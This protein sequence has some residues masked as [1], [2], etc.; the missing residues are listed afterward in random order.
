MDHNYLI[1]KGNKLPWKIPAEMKYFSQI[2]SGNTVLMGSKTFESIG[3]PLKNRQNI[4]ITKNPEKYRNWQEKSLIF[5]DNLNEILK[6]YKN[7]PK[8]HV[9]VIGG[10]EIYQ[11]TYFYADYYYVSVVKGVYEGNIYFPFPTWKENEKRENYSLEKIFENFKLIKKEEF[12]EFIA[13]IYQVPVEI[14]LI[15][16]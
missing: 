3:K 13:Y 9:F 12:S 10:R 7:N 4:V 5:S 1:G 8:N 6:P 14:Y 16:N 11:Q 15:K 2:T